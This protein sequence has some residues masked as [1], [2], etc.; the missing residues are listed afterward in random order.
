MCATPLPGLQ[1]VSASSADN[2]L[3]KSASV[4]CPA[5]KRVVSVGGA[6][7]GAG[8]HAYLDRLVPHGAGWNGADVEAREDRLGTTG[9]WTASVYAI[10]AY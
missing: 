1:M 4:E 6:I 5:G 9:S 7:Y 2:S 10:C 3:D 8:G